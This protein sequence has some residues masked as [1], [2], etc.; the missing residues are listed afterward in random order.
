[1]LSSEEQVVEVLL[2]AR[3]FERED[4]LDNNE[5][6]DREGEQIDL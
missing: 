6:N 5:Q 2:S 1:M 4:A 3:L